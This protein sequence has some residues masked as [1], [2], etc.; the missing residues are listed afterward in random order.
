MSAGMVG[1]VEGVLKSRWRRGDRSAT[2]LSP[3]FQ[4]NRWQIHPL[5][6]GRG[7]AGN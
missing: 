1:L 7:G 2:R 3:F 6:P 4:V 5:I